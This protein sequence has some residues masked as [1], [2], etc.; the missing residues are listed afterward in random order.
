M[1]SLGNKFRQAKSD[2]D[3]L[4][5][6]HGFLKGKVCYWHMCVKCVLTVCGERTEVRNWGCLHPGVFNDY[7]T[8]TGC[9]KNLPQN[10]IIVHHNNLNRFMTTSSFKPV[11]SGLPRTVWH[12]SH[13]TAWIRCPLILYQTTDHTQFIKRIANRLDISCTMSSFQIQYDEKWWN[14]TFLCY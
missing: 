3:V 5:T 13:N 14:A 10:M 1:L 6:A 2:T 4:H 7:C 11:W 12:D 9:K 8:P